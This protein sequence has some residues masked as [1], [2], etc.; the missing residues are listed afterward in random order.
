METVLCTRF[1]SRE[2]YLAEATHAAGTGTWGELI[3]VPSMLAP[4]FSVTKY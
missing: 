2:L 1:E 4:V 3:T